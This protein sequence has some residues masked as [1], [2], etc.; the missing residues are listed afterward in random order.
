MK[1]KIIFILCG[2]AMAFGMASCRL[3]TYSQSGGKADQAYLLFVS[4]ETYS[5]KTVQVTIDGKTTFDAK[6]VKNRDS[7]IKGGLYAIATGDKNIKVMKDGKV[8]YEK[9]IF[10]STQETKKIVLP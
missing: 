9:T 6:V 8:L 1:R 7:K 2:V 4:G 3:G 5:D 10:A